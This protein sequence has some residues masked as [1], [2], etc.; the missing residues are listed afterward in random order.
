MAVGEHFLNGPATGLA[1]MLLLGA[2]SI[3]RGNSRFDRHRSSGSR[4]GFDGSCDRLTQEVGVVA[5]FYWLAGWRSGCPFPAS[6]EQQRHR[7]PQR[8]GR[9]DLRR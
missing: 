6:V 5:R 1:L 4:A 7:L 3:R 9:G 2:G 8:E